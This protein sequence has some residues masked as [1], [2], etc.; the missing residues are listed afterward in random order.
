M[1]A[2]LMPTT[3]LLSS[4]IKKSGKGRAKDYAS[5]D[6]APEPP[7][8]LTIKTIRDEQIAKRP[9]KGT[10]PASEDLESAF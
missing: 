2:R 7:H 3:T 1:R 9:E 5:S 6:L 8:R 4:L 10:I